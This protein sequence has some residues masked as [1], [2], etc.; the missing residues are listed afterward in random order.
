[1][2]DSSRLSIVPRRQVIR[3]S[4]TMS[5]IQS[6]LFNQLCTEAQI[7][8]P[9]NRYPMVTGREFMAAAISR[10]FAALKAKEALESVANGTAVAAS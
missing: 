7:Q 9:L 8:G 3:K 2:I 6:R 5:Q 1:M 10:N 4:I